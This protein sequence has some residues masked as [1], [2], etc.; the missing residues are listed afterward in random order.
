MKRYTLKEQL[1][2]IQV[3]N[4]QNHFIKNYAFLNIYIYIYSA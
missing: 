1:L 4:L 2:K 3:L